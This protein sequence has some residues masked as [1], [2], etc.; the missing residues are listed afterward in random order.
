MRA[1]FCVYVSTRVDTVLAVCML[2]RC[3]SHFSLPN[4]VCV[5]GWNGMREIERE[6]RREKQQSHYH[7]MRIL[8]NLKWN[9]KYY[10]VSVGCCG[11]GIPWLLFHCGMR[12]RLFHD[13][14]FRIADKNIVQCFV[15]SFLFFASFPSFLL[16]KSHSCQRMKIYDFASAMV[17]SFNMYF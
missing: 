12:L 10:S 7:C 9:T 5:S 17:I 11:N 8:L 13:R 16:R 1:C 6:S 4:G 15:F 2:R 14:A 3:A